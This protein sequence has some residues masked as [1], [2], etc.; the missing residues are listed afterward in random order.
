MKKKNP[1]FVTINRYY[2]NQKVTYS[3][4]RNNTRRSDELIGL[5]LT[6]GW[7]PATP[8]VF[9]RTKDARKREQET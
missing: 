8:D 6:K 2:G 1:N 4:R 7:N 3:V 5:S 9:K